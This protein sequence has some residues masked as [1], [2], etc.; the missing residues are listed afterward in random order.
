MKKGGD[1]TKDVCWRGMQPRSFPLGRM[2]VAVKGVG[3]SR[4]DVLLLVVLAS[5]K[6]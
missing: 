6:E 1:G 3:D 4:V 2:L 5:Q